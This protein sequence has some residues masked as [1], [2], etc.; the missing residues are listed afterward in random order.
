M[1]YMYSPQLGSSPYSQL[2]PLRIGVPLPGHSFMTGHAYESF[3]FI[4][5]STPLQGTFLSK[6]LVVGVGSSYM[7]ERHYLKKIVTQ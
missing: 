6:N 5:F 3:T 1:D 4:L 2:L 7:K